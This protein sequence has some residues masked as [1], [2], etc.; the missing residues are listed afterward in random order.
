MVLSASGLSNSID[1]KCLSAKR[2]FHLVCFCVLNKSIFSLGFMFGSIVGQFWGHFWVIFCPFEVM[3]D[4]QDGL[5]G[6]FGHIDVILDA[7]WG[8]RGAIRLDLGVILG[9][10][11]AQ[12]RDQNDIKINV[13]KYNECRVICFASLVVLGGPFWSICWDL[14]VSGDDSRQ[15]R[16]TCDL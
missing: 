7:T 4:P 6:H 13:E 11:W 14:F 16:R 3:L 15:K 5:W 12:F 9:S 1:E 8:P 10:I 2:A